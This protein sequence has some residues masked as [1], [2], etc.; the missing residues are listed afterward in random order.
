MPVNSL[1]TYSCWKLLLALKDSELASN[2]IIARDFNVVLY[3]Y[4]KM[5]RNI[6]RDP[7]RENMKDFIVECDLID[8]KPIKRK[9]T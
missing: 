6:V 2:N 1:K 9:F 7:F 4:E 8:I 3:N 5:G